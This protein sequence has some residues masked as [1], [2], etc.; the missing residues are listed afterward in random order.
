MKTIHDIEYEDL[1]LAMAK[2]MKQ[3]AENS[4]KL[5]KHKKMRGEKLKQDL[6]ADKAFWAQPAVAKPFKVEEKECILPSFVNTSIKA[7]I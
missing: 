4:Q 3:M 5:Y 7:N 2:W 1:P 6:I